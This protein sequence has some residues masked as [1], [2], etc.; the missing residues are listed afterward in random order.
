M[1]LREWPD[2]FSWYPGLAI[3]LS[4][5]G[6]LALELAMIRWTSS[7][8]RIFAYFNNMVLICAFLGMGS[9]Y[10]FLPTTANSLS[11]SSNGAPAISAYLDCTVNPAASNSPCRLSGLK[12]CN[13]L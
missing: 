12:Y 9:D 10:A 11:V 8:V 3:G 13:Q 7:Q 6:I 2:R 1:G 5:F 4:T